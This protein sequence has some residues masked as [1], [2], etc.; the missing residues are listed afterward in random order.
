MPVWYGAPSDFAASTQANSSSVSGTAGKI[1]ST[2]V[3]EAP[4]SRTAPETRMRSPSRTFGCKAPQLPMRIM[5]V[6]P[7]LRSSST[8]MP[9]LAPPMPV[10]TASTGTP[11][12]SPTRL[13]YSRLYASSRTFSRNGAMRSSRA[14][15]PGRRAQRAPAVSSKRIC[16]CRLITKYLP[17][18]L[19]FC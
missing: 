5:A 7:M 6:T 10:E 8:A 1:W 14:G 11:R 18:H 16:G 4:S 15:S 19:F 9:A 3:F 17:F 12:Y 2:Y 13:R